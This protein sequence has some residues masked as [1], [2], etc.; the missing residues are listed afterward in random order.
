M[1]QHSFIT[2]LLI[3]CF[4]YACY[5]TSKNQENILAPYIF[6]EE[7]S[8][9]KQQTIQFA[10]NTRIINDIFNSNNDL[11]FIS[12]LNMGESDDSILLIIEP[13]NQKIK[14]IKKGS[15]SKRIISN[16]NDNANPIILD[17]FSIKNQQYG[18]I[19]NPQLNINIQ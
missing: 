19:I 5:Q 3:S 11:N 8:N 13:S 14:Q 9:S 7:V 10:P 18:N 2:I 17:F 16:I 1:L 4:L 12:S 15:D 6:K